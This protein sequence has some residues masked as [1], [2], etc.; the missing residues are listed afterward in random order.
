MSTT[1]SEV[2]PELDR[3]FNLPSSHA[4][5]A[6][7]SGWLAVVSPFVL[8][9]CIWGAVKGGQNGASGAARAWFGVAVAGCCVFGI[10]LIAAP[11]I[12]WSCA[13]DAAR[14]RAFR[15]GLRDGKYLVRWRYDE[16]QWRAFKGHV[17]KTKW[18]RRWDLIWIGILMVATPIV[19]G[20]A[21]NGAAETWDTPAQRADRRSTA[22]FVILVIEAALVFAA[23][24]CELARRTWQK[25]LEGNSVTVIGTLCA[26]A[27]GHWILWGTAGRLLTGVTVVGGTDGTPTRLAITTNNGNVDTVE[28]VLVPDGQRELAEKVA[29]AVSAAPKTGGGLVAAGNVMQGLVSILRMFR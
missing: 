11:M 6:T 21:V 23:G 18:A 5:A 24:L 1:R 13:S 10:A 29:A 17:F 25:R 20:M 14:V 28:E 4:K 7:I 8:A 26:F 3:D 27:N 12:Y 15:K 16:A 2:R 9:L 22:V 19:A